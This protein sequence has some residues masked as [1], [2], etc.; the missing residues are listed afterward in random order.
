MKVIYVAR[1]G[2]LF[3]DVEQC[4]MY[5][6]KN[7]EESYFWDEDKKL[8]DNESFLDNPNVCHYFYTLSKSELSIIKKIIGQRGRR[9]IMDIS[10]TGFYSYDKYTNQWIDN[11]E[12]AR[13]LIMEKQKCLNQVR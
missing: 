8:L 5:E 1:D 4:L 13:K 9:K 10:D 3:E 12:V 7:F 11:S 6:S 2:M